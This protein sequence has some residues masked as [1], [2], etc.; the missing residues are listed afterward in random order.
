MEEF[1]HSHNGL[2]SLNLL[3]LFSFF[4][5][6]FSWKAFFS[7]GTYELVFVFAS[8]GVVFLLSIVCVVWFFI[9]FLSLYFPLYYR[10]ILLF[11]GVHAIF[12][13][14]IALWGK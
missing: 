14:N 11:C 6:F 3:S 2:I 4:I 9:S 10:C 7:L 5:S 12:L 13:K 8:L 1:P